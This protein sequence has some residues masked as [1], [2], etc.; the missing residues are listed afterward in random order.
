[1]TI[2]SP[3]TQKRSL[4]SSTFSFGLVHRVLSKL[5]QSFKIHVLFLKLRTHRVGE[6]PLNL[7]SNVFQI[8][9]HMKDN[10]WKVND[11]PKYLYKTSKFTQN[12]L[13]FY[14]YLDSLQIESI[15]FFLYKKN[16]KILVLK[17][18]IYL[19][20]LKL[21]SLFCKTFTRTQK[22]AEIERSQST[23]P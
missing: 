3:L 14:F 17:T 13:H 22:N 18:L 1:M 16:T 12:I 15:S 8:F 4:L 20:H 23:K 10:L 5:P 2:L 7:C 6:Q 9:H 11:S 19:C 21:V